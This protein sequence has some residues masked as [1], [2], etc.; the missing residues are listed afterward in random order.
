MV[1]SYVSLYKKIPLEKIVSKPK[2]KKNVKELP[3]APM[4]FTCQY[5]FITIN[6]EEI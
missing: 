6:L 1:I 3:V 2:E 4:S 5:T